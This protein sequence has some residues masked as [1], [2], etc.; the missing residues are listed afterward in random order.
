MA[1]P[2]KDFYISRKEYLEQ[3]ISYKDEQLIKVVTGMRRCGKSTL[4]FDIYF[5]WLIKSGVSDEQIIRVDLESLEFSALYE[6]EALY[7]YVTD[8]LIQGKKNYVLIDEVQN[9]KEFQRAVDSLYIKKDVD[10]YITGSNAYL[11]SG[12]LATLLS[13]RYVTIEMLPLSFKEYLEGTSGTDAP[14]EKKYRDYVLFGGL[15]KVAAY[16]G[17]MRKINSY[18]DGI[19]NTIFKK[20]IVD[21]NKIVNVPLFE[22]VMKFVMSN[23]GSPISTKSISDF[24][25]SNRKKVYAPMIEDFLQCLIDSYMIYKA[26]RF[27]IKGKEL[28]KSLAKYYVTDLGLRNYLLG[29]Q[30]IDRGHVLENVIYTELLRRGY[31]V[32]TGKT[33]NG[34]IDFV[35]VKQDETTY[36]QVA[37]TVKAQE[38]LERELAPLRAIR[39]FNPRMLITLDYDLN[40]SYDGIKHVNALEFL[41]G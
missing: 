37:E 9:C 39:D 21:R 40:S 8:R 36:V 11:F 22:D 5:D 18:L 31:R 4:L 19:Y 24:L 35:A 26:Q 15:P 29:Y 7:K 38:T 3:L 14:L 13:G 16:K 33:A 34:E 12:E 41:M 20:D 6:P 28:L 1:E 32:F 10:V 27:D 2:K 25:T 30:D 17:D 23:I